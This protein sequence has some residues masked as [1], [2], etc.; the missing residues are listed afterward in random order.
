MVNT[1]LGE[2]LPEDN[3]KSISPDGVAP[4]GAGQD[5]E[6]GGQK[7]LSRGLQGR[8]MQM[9]AIGMLLDPRNIWKTY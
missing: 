8:H 5:V 2:K 1:S 3:E 4:P 6:V 9:I 7:A